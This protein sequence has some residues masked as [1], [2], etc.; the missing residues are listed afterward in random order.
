MKELKL[1]DFS[2]RSPPPRRRRYHLIPRRGNVGAGVDSGHLVPGRVV[3]VERESANVNRRGDVERESPAGRTGNGHGNEREFGHASVNRMVGQALRVLE[4]ER[5]D[6]RAEETKMRRLLGGDDF[7]RGRVPRDSYLRGEQSH[8]DF[9]KRGPAL[10]PASEDRPHINRNDRSRHS[11]SAGTPAGLPPRDAER[12]EHEEQLVR[13]PPAARQGAGGRPAQ[14]TSG[15]GTTTTAFFHGEQSPDS[16]SPPN[17]DALDFGRVLDLQ[18]LASRPPRGGA[19]VS[20]SGG[21]GSE[22]SEEEAIPPS[23]EREV[24]SE[25]CESPEQRKRAEHNLGGSVSDVGGVFIVGPTKTPERL[26]FSPALCDLIEDSKLF[27]VGGGKTDLVFF[28]RRTMWEILFLTLE[29]VLLPT[30]WKIC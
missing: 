21:G 14:T 7:D 16:P 27:Q 25:D 28:V 10:S 24:R 13:D 22:G 12:D 2:G 20:P 26:G 8:D 4:Q 18:K 17:K 15:P 9:Y 29:N 1:L 11:S 30:V 5:H 23:P 3:D 6:S 19:V